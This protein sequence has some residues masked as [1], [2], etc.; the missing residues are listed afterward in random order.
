MQSL[1]YS[2]RRTLSFQNFPMLTVLANIFLG[3]ALGKTLVTPSDELGGSML[4]KVFLIVGTCLFANYL[5]CLRRAFKGISRATNGKLRPLLRDG[6]RCSAL[7][8]VIL[9]A[10]LALFFLKPHIL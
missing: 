5:M 9:A 4:I 2:L 7:N 10:C 8:A 1:I 3:F 6:L